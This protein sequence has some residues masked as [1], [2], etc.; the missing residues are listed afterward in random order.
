MDEDAFFK[1]ARNFSPVP[2]SLINFE[3]VYKL[4]LEGL[5]MFA[6]DDNYDLIVID[7]FD[8]YCWDLDISELKEFAKKKDV[9]ILL[10][11]QLRRP[12]LWSR[13]KH[14]V[15]SDVTFPQKH[16]ENKFVSMVDI[17]LFGYGKPNTN[18]IWVSVGKNIYGSI[19]TV[20]EFQK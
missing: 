16:L 7:P 1:R 18:K 13:R 15:L 12:P 5:K 10:S 8:T 4:T 20:L 19:G 11:K 3:E 6:S 9:C 17:I 2:C 14:P